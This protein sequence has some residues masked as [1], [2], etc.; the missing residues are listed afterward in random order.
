MAHDTDPTPR[1]L[2]FSG[3]ELHAQLQSAIRAHGLFCISPDGYL[4]K[5]AE[6]VDALAARIDALKS[7]AAARRK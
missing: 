7:A 4:F 1:L 5:L 3:Q 2:R 6:I